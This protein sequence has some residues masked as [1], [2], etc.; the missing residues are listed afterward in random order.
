MTLAS[1]PAAL[2][3]AILRA[4]FQIAPR[5]ATR[6]N[7][8]RGRQRPQA[9]Y[10]PR[11]DARRH[12]PDPLYRRPEGP[13]RALVPLHAPQRCGLVP[14]RLPRRRHELPGRACPL[15]RRRPHILDPHTPGTWIL[16]CRLDIR[17]GFPPTSAPE[18][19]S[20]R[21]QDNTTI[22]LTWAP[23]A[24]ATAYDVEYATDNTFATPMTI[25]SVT[26]PAATVTGLQPGTAYIFRVWATNPSGRGSEASA[27]ARATTQARPARPDVTATTSISADWGDDSLATSYE[28]RHAA[29]RAGLSAATPVTVRTSQYTILRSLLRH[30]T[31]DPDPRLRP[32]RTIGLERAAISADARSTAPDL[33]RAQFGHPGRDPQDGRHHKA[34]GPEEHHRLPL[35]ANHRRLIPDRHI[36]LDRVHE[37][38]LRHP[39]RCRQRPLPISLVGRHS[40]L[41]I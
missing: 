37:D 30:D 1:W 23:A 10:R 6:H 38:L 3:Q 14:A 25:P 16:S 26:E 18:A 20:A 29:I 15:L 39:Q 21:A 41:C 2:P 28:L 34:A 5:A 36:P 35:P 4:G 40:S 13:V 8:V 7:A 33:H 12:M 32:R 17:A 22:H 11:P 31:M 9:R 19:L 27:T 24:D